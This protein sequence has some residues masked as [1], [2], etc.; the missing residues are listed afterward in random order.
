MDENKDFYKPMLKSLKCIKCKCTVHEL[1]QN[2]NQKKKSVNN[3]QCIM[4]TDKEHR[5]RECV[6]CKNTWGMK[7]IFYEND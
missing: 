6:V 3:F 7:K 1:C 5:E 4:C 2:D